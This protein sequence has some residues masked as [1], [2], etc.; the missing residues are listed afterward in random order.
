MRSG[1]P[2]LPPLPGGTSTLMRNI[3]GPGSGEINARS[4]FGPVT[5]GLSIL[6][7]RMGPRR[8]LRRVCLLVPLDLEHQTE[9]IRSDGSCSHP[10]CDLSTDPS[11][12]TYAKEMGSGGLC[13][14]S[15]RPETS[16]VIGGICR[17]VDSGSGFR[18]QRLGIHSLAVRRSPN[19]DRLSGALNR[20]Q[21]SRRCFTA[22]FACGSC[23]RRGSRG[24]DRPL[25]QPGGLYV[26]RWVISRSDSK[27][28]WK[29]KATAP[30][31]TPQTRLFGRYVMYI[32]TRSL[33]VSFQAHCS[34]ITFHLGVRIQA[35]TRG[36][37]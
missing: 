4:R 33:P 11:D 6:Q 1:A 13:L 14:P 32:C 34:P 31:P 12:H 16:P 7:P 15:Q 8:F 22:V 24:F 9:F 29:Q 17:Y 28:S 30:P 3:L 21:L 23:S 37:H 20:S 27:R 2:P 36:T 25:G 10:P 26:Q 18:G 35:S 5:S 19:L